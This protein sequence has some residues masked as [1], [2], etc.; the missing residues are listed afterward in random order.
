MTQDKF[1]K[2][3]TKKLEDKDREYFWTTVEVLIV[4]GLFLWLTWKLG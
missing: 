4:I 3:A 2:K 1:F